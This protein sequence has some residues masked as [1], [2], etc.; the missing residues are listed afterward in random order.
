MMEA[1]RISETLVSFYQTTRRYNPEDSHLGYISCLRHGYH[2]YHVYLRYRGH[3]VYFGYRCVG[4]RGDPGVDDPPLGVKPHVG[5][6][7][8]W[9]RVPFLGCGP[10]QRVRFFCGAEPNGCGGA[11]REEVTPHGTQPPVGAELLCGLRCVKLGLVGLGFG[12]FCFIM[13]GWVI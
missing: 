3:L 5:R 8:D 10:Q 1:A 13:L 7:D 11:L 12:M 9:G 6:P 2:V 4:P